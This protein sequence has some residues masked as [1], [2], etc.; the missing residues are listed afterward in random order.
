VFWCTRASD[1]W[2]FKSLGTRSLATESC[3]IERAH[4]RETDGLAEAT[5]P[6]VGSWLACAYLLVRL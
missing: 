6:R 3:Y 1:T 4:L 2:G 5:S